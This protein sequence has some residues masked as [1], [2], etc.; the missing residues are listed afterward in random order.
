MIAICPDLESLYI[1]IYFNQ[2]ICPRPSTNQ[3][4]PLTVSQAEPE[5]TPVSPK[6]EAVPIAAVPQ[7]SQRIAA[8]QSQVR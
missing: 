7:D 5:P 6:V 1:Y 3:P 4:A 8:M 2:N